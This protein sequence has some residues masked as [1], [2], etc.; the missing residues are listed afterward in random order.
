MIKRSSRLVAAFLALVTLVAGVTFLIENPDLEVT[1]KVNIPVLDDSGAT[2]ESLEAVV[3]ASNTFAFDLYRRYSSG[4]DNLFYSPYSIST[5][6]SMTYEGA[7]G[8]TAEEIR[9]VFHLPEDDE[10]RRPGAARVYNI[11]NGK[12]RPYTLL[13]ANALWMQEGY[14]FKEDYV[15]TIQGYYGGEAN[16]LDF[17][18]TVEATEI[19]N[20]WV[21]DRTYDK[22]KDLFSPGSLEGALLVLTNAIYFKGDWAT[23]FDEADTRAADFH[24]TPTATVEA[25]MM[26]M[27]GDLNY[28]ETGEAQVL[29]LPY[30]GDDLSMV[31]ILPKRNDIH[32]FEAGF[33]MEEYG[34][35]VAALEQTK[36]KVFLPR[37]KLE[38]RYDMGRDLAEMGMPTAFSG[39]ADFSGIS[40]GG[41][42]ISQVIHQAYVDV[43]E[44]GTEAAA[45]TGVVMLSAAPM[46]EEFRADHPFIFVIRDRG[47]GLILFMGR[48]VDPS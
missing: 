30:K 11:L 21:E 27:E 23:Q 2:P 28:A 5:A 12:D 47:T 39:G 31:V 18:N 33:T 44:K 38:T 29:E 22:I 37:Y 16:T 25:E 43:N 26:S 32:G 24:V 17:S 40:N 45:A 36:L 3:E 46:L 41:L 19:I 14:P 42:Y 15:Q 48:V 8:A 34:E 9:T 6:L 4:E 35:Y 10:A 13:T 1:S 7:R 20:G